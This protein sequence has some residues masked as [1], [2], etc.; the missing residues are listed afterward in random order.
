MIQTLRKD[1]SFDCDKNCFGVHDSPGTG[2][3]V[4][5]SIL[6]MT[7]VVPVIPGTIEKLVNLRLN[8]IT[9]PMKKL[10]HGKKERC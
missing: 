4:D 5:A 2:V 3:K 8:G 6:S 7:S 9:F 1:V 10:R